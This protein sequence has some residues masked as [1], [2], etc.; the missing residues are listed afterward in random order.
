VWS[1][2]SFIYVPPGVNVDQPLQATFASTPRTWVSS[3]ARSSSPTKDPRSTTSRAARR[4]SIR[5]TRCTRRSS[6]SSPCRLA[7]HLHHHSELV[8]QRLQ[9]RDEARSRRSRGARRVDRCNI[10]SRLTMKYPSVYLMGP[11][12]RARSFGRLR[13]TG[14]GPRRRREDDPLRS[15][16]DLDIISKSISKDG[17]QTTYRGL[18]KVEEGATGAKSFV[19]CDALILDEQSVSE[20]K[21]TW[22]S[23]SKTRRS[24]TRRRC[25]KSVTTSC[26]IS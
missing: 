21:P 16:D 8:E 24:V 18:V 23:V 22:R 11:K 13:R 19:R 20:T 3:S 4:R 26:S 9:P 12:P 7:H 25:R 10:G 17:G 6:S 14:S 15:G 5:P 2:G 1:G